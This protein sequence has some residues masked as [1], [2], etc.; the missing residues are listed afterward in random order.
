MA[1]NNP[2][3]SSLNKYLTDRTVKFSEDDIRANPMGYSLLAKLTRN[4]SHEAFDNEGNLTD[5]RP[6]LDFLLG[7]SSQKAQDIDDNEA[8]MQLLPDLERAALLLISYIISPNNLKSAQ[9]QYKLP[10]SIFPQTV[11][12]QMVEVMQDYLEKDYRLSDRV[13]NILYDVL[14]TKDRIR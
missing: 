1:K 4:P 7:I 14:F 8:I 13:Y 2:L 9:M 11:S 12:S 10:D 6:S 3:L 5:T